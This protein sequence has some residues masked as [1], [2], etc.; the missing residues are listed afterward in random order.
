MTFCRK[1][2]TTGSAIN[3]MPSL[4]TSFRY[5]SARRLELMLGRIDAIAAFS[6]LSIRKFLSAAACAGGPGQYLRSLS[7]EYHI[8]VTHVDPNLLPLRITQL[9]IVSI[10]QVFEDF[11]DAFKGEHPLSFSWSARKQEETKLDHLWANVVGSGAVT[12]E[13]QGEL[14]LVEYYR[15]ARNRFL[16]GSTKKQPKLTDLHEIVRQH[17]ALRKCSGPNG[18]DGLN[19]E[20]VVIFARSVLG[21]AQAL[22]RNSIPTEA[23][24]VAMVRALDGKDAAPGLP[25]VRLK[26]YRKF[27]HNAKRLHGKLSTLL[28]SLYGIQPGSSPAVIAELA[29]GLLA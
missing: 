7:T 22:C 21:V 29:S 23:Q 2:L 5:P 26:E 20:D 13:T 19:F 28:H 4:V 10:H 6:E 27:R 25:A 1:V 14:V 17:P 15:F 16:H 12:S 24:V 18:Y 8:N 11:L 3:S 9:Q